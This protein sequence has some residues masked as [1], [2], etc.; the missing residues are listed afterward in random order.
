MATRKVMFLKQWSQEKAID[1]DDE[2]SAKREMVRLLAW[3]ATVEQLDTAM[4]ALI[5]EDLNHTERRTAV[6]QSL[7]NRAQVH[8]PL[9]SSA[10]SEAS[11][12]DSITARK[13]YLALVIKWN[14]PVDLFNG[15]IRR[16]NAGRPLGADNGSMTKKP[17]QLVHPGEKSAE[18]ARS[19]GR[20]RASRYEAISGLIADLLHLAR[21]DNYSLSRCLELAEH[22]IGMFIAEN[23]ARDSEAPA[24]TS[25][26]DY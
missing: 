19:R 12:H 26:V 14:R 24:V 9:S 13:E 1:M 3:D 16:R 11:I 4:R 2:L 8:L 22:G 18:G 17:W 5:P 23:R 20:G 25:A 10:I 7:T 21:R 6:S 15:A